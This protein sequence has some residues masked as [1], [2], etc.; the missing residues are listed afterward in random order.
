MTNLVDFYRYELVRRSGK[1]NMIMEAEAAAKAANLDLLIYCQV[2]R[3]YEQ[4]KQIA[5]S[6]YGSIDKFMGAYAG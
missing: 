3:N 1:Y 2:I 5:E 4:L 6:K